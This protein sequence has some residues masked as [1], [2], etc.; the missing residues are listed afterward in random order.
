MKPTFSSITHRKVARL[1]LGLAIAGSVAMA[2]NSTTAAQAS[3]GPGTNCPAIS[4][5]GYTGWPGG[6]SISGQCF[7]EGGNVYV[8]VYDNVTQAQ[9]LGAWTTA[10]T[11]QWVCPRWSC[12]WVPGGDVSYQSSL[13]C[14][15]AGHQLTVW[16]YDGQTATWSNGVN[17]AFECLH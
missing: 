4:A 15:S 13:P 6:V 17:V 10:S 5:N 1:I 7:S 11:G 9:I 3:G 2:A 12:Y 14:S 8:D 16:A